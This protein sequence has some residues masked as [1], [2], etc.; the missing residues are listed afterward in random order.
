M[1]DCSVNL[2]IKYTISNVFILKSTKGASPVV[3]PLYASY[4][5]MFSGVDKFNQER[6]GKD[7]KYRAGGYKH[8]G[9]YGAQHRFAL[10]TTLVNVYN[11]YLKGH[12]LSPK[13][14]SYKLMCE[15]LAKDLWKS[16]N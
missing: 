1:L 8:S 4:N 2:G 9:Y 15:E 16:I 7:F 12:G 3:S 13:D 14:Y 5:F 10:G 6:H 11:C